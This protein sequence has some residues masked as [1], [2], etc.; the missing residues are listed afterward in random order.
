MLRVWGGIVLVYRDRNSEVVDF[1]SRYAQ[2]YEGLSALEYE[3]SSKI[4]QLSHERPTV[5][6]TGYLSSVAPP[7]GPGRPQQQ[8]KFTSLRRVGNARLG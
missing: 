3:I 7:M 8:P 4:W 5:G 6:L 1:A 2:G